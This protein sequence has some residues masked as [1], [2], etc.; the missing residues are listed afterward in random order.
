MINI[1][2]RTYVSSV[3]KALILINV[4]MKVTITHYLNAGRDT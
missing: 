2:V 1:C 4:M 3:G